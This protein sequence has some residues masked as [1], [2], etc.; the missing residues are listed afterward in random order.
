MAFL[1]IARNLKVGVD[2]RLA[3]AQARRVELDLRLGGIGL[4]LGQHLLRL[5]PLVQQDHAFVI[6]GHADRRLDH[7]T[8]GAIL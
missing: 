4:E 6:A 1:L 5:Q 7:V 2:L 8:A 3:E